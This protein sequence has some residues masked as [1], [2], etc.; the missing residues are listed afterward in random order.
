[1]RSIR[2]KVQFISFGLALLVGSLVPLFGSQAA[3]AAATG[4]CYFES[5][6]SVPAYVGSCKSQFPNLKDAAGHTINL[7]LCYDVSASNI[8]TKLDCSN[9]KLDAGA[10]QKASCLSHGG[11]YND[12]TGVCTGETI[13]TPNTV[14]TGDKCADPA[15]NSGNCT[16]A[17]HCDLM[18]KYVYP[19]INFLSALVGVVVIISIIIGG[20]QYGS[21][22]GDP[23]KV[24]A[25]KNRIRNSI[26]ALVTFIFLYALLNFLVPGGVFNG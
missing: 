22:A 3:L 26:I 16:D 8:A 10:A 14:C 20:I 9:S 17:S 12:K 13:A 4:T 21:S 7:S 18:S 1:M 11:T 15:I 5:N 19:F 2:Q 24:T 6:G 23:A 25:A